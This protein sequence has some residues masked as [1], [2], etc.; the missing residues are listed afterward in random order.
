MSALP[1]PFRS[2]FRSLTVAPLHGCEPRLRHDTA[3]HDDAVMMMITRAEYR[4]TRSSYI[5]LSRRFAAIALIDFAFQ[6]PH[7]FTDH[8]TSSAVKP[9]AILLYG[10]R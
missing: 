9:A 2:P 4:V 8:G 5:D 6:P 1:P 3:A 10:R 7:E